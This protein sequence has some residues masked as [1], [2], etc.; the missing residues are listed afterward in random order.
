MASNN[1]TEDPS[2]ERLK[3]R[4]LWEKVNDPKFIEE[5]IS[6]KGGRSSPE[7][8]TVPMI[9]SDLLRGSTNDVSGNR[10]FNHLR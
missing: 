4:L 3:K 6:K 5:S 8:A 7:K 1:G 10:V 9:S 2:D